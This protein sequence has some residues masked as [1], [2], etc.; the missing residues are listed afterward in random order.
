MSH[1]DWEWGCSIRRIKADFVVAFKGD[2]VW[3]AAHEHRQELTELISITVPG[4]AALDFQA[5]SAGAEPARP[6]DR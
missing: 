6:S 3:M 2:P 1:P 4:Q 5:G